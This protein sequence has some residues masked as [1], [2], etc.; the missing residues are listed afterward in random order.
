M[1]DEK[2]DGGRYESSFMNTNFATEYTLPAFSTF[3]K[4]N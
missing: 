1:N 2:G 3:K 4:V